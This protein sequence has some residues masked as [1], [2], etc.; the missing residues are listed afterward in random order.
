M[1]NLSTLEFEILRYGAVNLRVLYTWD[2]KEKLQCPWTLC[3]LYS[4]Q[5]SH[6]LIIWI[7]N[8][9]IYFNHVMPATLEYWT[10]SPNCNTIQRTL[11]LIGAKVF[12]KLRENILDLKVNYNVESYS[13]IL[14]TILVGLYG[15]LGHYSPVT[16]AL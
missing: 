1:L 15:T 8:C 7:G 12:P 2:R 9:Y 5:H 16:R 4:D 13:E 11:H 6:H 10:W 3:D 14:R